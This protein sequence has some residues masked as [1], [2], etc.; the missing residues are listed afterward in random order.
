[1]FGVWTK[2]YGLVM[3]RSEPDLD[4]MV[5]TPWY[6]QYAVADDLFE[7]VQAFQCPVRNLELS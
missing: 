2:I 6:H 1:M 3:L 4:I 5:L 7:D